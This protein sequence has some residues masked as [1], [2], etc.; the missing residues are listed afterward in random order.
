VVVCTFGRKQ[1]EKAEQSLCAETFSTS[2][3]WVAPKQQ[4]YNVITVMPKARHV[5]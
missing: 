2:V 1:D 5:L 3:M 4:Q